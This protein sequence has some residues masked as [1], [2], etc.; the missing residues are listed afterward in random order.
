METINQTLLGF[1]QALADANRLRIV[2]VL[3]QGPQT[4]EQISALLGLGMSTTSHHLANW[5]RPG[6]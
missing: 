3:A 6:W 1:F 4:V 2:G 5:P